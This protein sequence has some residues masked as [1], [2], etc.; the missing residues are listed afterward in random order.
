MKKA[1]LVLVILLP[2][3]LRAQETFDTSIK[4]SLKDSILLNDTF[5]KLVK[6]IKN[7]N[8]A[9]VLHI[10]LPKVNCTMCL[11][12]DNT[13]IPFISAKQFYEYAANNFTQSAV[14]KSFLKNGYELYCNNFKDLKPENLPQDFVGDLIV[15]ELNIE[16]NL[17]DTQKSDKQ[18]QNNFFFFIKVKNEFKL[19]AITSLPYL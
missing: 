8:E 5:N 3:L 6:G 16:T 1:F 14:Y 7:K 15:Y 9:E 12:S 10:S 11:D 19:F 18:I 13:Y 4:V 2:F 17:D